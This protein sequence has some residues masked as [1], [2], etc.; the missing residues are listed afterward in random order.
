[1]NQ[2][3]FIISGYRNEEYFCNRQLETERMLSSI[4]NQRHLTLFSLRRMGKTGLIWHVFN[5][6]KPEKT[7]VPVY[8]DIMPTLNI[9]DF[10][11]SLAKAVFSTLAQKQSV[12]KKLLT[13]L[14]SL[15]PTLSYDSL[16]GN[17]EI[18]IQMDS[19]TDVEYS[20]ESVF[21][22]LAGQD[23]Q[24]I[25]ALDE[26]QQ[27]TS[28]GEKGVEALIRSH[29]QKLNN[30]VFLF[31]GSRRHLLS[32]IFSNPNRPFFN[33]TEIMEI[34]TIEA[35]SY[36]RFIDHHFQKNNRKIQA[37]AL[38]EIQHHT[39]LHTFYVQFLCNRLY[40]TGRRTIKKRDVAHMFR[41]V[42]AENESIY[43]SYI[44]LITPMQFRLLKAFAK[45]NGAGG[46]TSKKYLKV[47]NLGAASSVNTASKSL[48]DKDF[49]YQ[50]GNK[51]FVID[52]FFKGWL[53][54]ID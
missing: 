11:L 44:N 48:L 24:F 12:I 6:L 27:I 49:I 51:Y 52:K 21:N 3:P 41:Q 36:K 8:V 28:Y 29:V 13:A 7:V 15:R 26:F 34:D 5:Q 31:S 14:A 30:V 54:G 47:H 38:D 45:D 23:Q 20:L 53:A 17:P 35:D 32:E 18:S 1:M 37:E 4:K 25:I 16:T 10:T 50:E 40:G 19:Q 42:I 33:S 2:N 46:I 22:L 39:A 43:A 9:S